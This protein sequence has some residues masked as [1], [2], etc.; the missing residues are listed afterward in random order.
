MEHPGGMG[1]P[2]ATVKSLEEQ[3]DVDMKYT[4]KVIDQLL[5]M[6]T[7]S[8]VTSAVSVFGLEIDLPCSQDWTL[9]YTMP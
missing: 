3:E 5:L 1:T 7:C 4:F 6:P 8:L 9:A 2:V